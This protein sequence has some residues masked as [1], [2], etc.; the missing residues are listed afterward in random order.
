MIGCRTC[1]TSYTSWN[2]KGDWYLLS[3]RA[4]IFNGRGTTVKG[5]VL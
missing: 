2:N 4:H 3:Y 1:R 5:H